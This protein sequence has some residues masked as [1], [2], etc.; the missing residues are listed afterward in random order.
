MDFS[1]IMQMAEQLKRE[2]QATQNAAQ[3]ARVVGEAGGGLVRVVLN[4]RYEAL[5]V[6]IEPKTLAGGDQTLIEDLLRAAFNQA[7]ARV[8]EQLQA[9]VGTFASSL[10]ID[11]QALEMFTKKP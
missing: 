7:S 10:G 11:P 8:A 5:E 9:R 4:G 6:H 2:L 3:E 1:Q